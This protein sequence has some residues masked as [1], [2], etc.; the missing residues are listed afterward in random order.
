MNKCV[1]DERSKKKFRLVF[2]LLECLVFRPGLSCPWFIPDNNERQ[3]PPE[4][5]NYVQ[6]LN[7]FTNKCIDNA[8][9]A[10]LLCHK[11]DFDECNFKKKMC[12]NQKLLIR[13]C[14]KLDNKGEMVLPI[15][16]FKSILELINIIISDEQLYK[17]TSKYDKNLSGKLP[18]L[19][20]IKEYTKV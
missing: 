12:Q 13:T 14:K 3:S 2:F 9:N 15:K 8:K 6:F 1:F 19:K 7:L 4:L 11:I 18:Y 10:N 5:I 17:I 20:L 16:E